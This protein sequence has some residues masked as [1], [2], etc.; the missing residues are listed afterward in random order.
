METRLKKKKSAWWVKVLKIIGIL[1]L[2]FC[3]F[4][5][6][7]VG[8][9]NK[10]YKLIVVESGSMSP[11]FEAGDLICI[12]K[13]D[14]KDIKIGDIVTFQTKDDKLLTH[15]IVDIKADGEI[16]TKGDANKANDSWND[17]WK[18]KEVE[19]KYVFTMPKL[20]YFINWWQGLILG[21]RTGANYKDTSISVGNQ[22]MAGDWSVPNP[23]PALAPILPPTVKPTVSPEPTDSIEPT[24]SPS[25][26]DSIEPTQSPTS[27]PTATATTSVEPTTSPT[28]SPSEAV[29]SSPPE[30][31][32]TTTETSQTTE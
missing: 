13:A 4:V 5:G 15:R 30:E 25:P 23:P 16:I 12:V 21:D 10:F 9:N 19:T 27:E 17:G 26:T 14:P 31:T 32:A 20:G 8:I 3:I 1:F 24:V 11:I 2:I 6:Y 28:A 29:T 7:G 22:I 18:L